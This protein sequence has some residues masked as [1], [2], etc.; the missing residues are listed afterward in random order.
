MP[1]SIEEPAVHGHTGG[2]R[3]E[4]QAMRLQLGLT[5]L[6]SQRRL[7]R[8]GKAP[9]IDCVDSIGLAQRMRASSIKQRFKQD[10][11]A[12]MP[13]PAQISARKVLIE[14]F[15]SRGGA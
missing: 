10:S 13:G 2:Q 15:N 14:R 1:A 3:T 12:G 7:R 6:G 11:S 9:L 5:P 8:R 4:T